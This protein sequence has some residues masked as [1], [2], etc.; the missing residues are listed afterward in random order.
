MSDHKPMTGDELAA[1]EKAPIDCAEFIEQ[2]ATVVPPIAGE[3]A[4]RAA[5]ALRATRGE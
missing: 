4:L 5:R 2:L 3:P 1:L